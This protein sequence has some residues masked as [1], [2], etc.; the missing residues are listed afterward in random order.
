[1][2]Q[3]NQTQRKNTLI[4]RVVARFHKTGRTRTAPPSA[5]HPKK[6]RPLRDSALV[7]G[8]L[9]A[10]GS[11]MLGSVTTFGIHYDNASAAQSRAL[12][13]S[14]A[15]L[16]QAIFGSDFVTDNVTIRMH[17]D[18]PYFSGRFDDDKPGERTL[19][20]VNRLDPNNVHMIAPEL[21]ASDY[22]RTTNMFDHTHLY[23]HE[24]AHV[25]QNR[26]ND[27]AASCDTYSYTLTAQSRF[28]DF[29]AEQQADM[30][31]D[32][33]VAYLIPNALQQ[34]AIVPAYVNLRFAG[35]TY[36]QADYDAR[37]NLVRVI[38]EQFPHARA[39]RLQIARNNDATLEC[40][41][42][43]VADDIRERPHMLTMP[44]ST[45]VSKNFNICAQRH[46]LTLDGQT[47]TATVEV[48]PVQTAGARRP[49]AS[50]GIG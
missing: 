46:L 47:Q 45:F 19:G 24:M 8:S 44:R 16:A 7:I 5:S 35:G 42:N 31:A 37:T 20:Y 2:Q 34:R 36:T 25:W 50:G 13:T 11:I 26:Q 18:R 9:L 4:D 14:E 21:H 10:G 17:A 3:N 29:C 23:V 33:A 48:S 41:F 22:G 12:T 15:T 6:S 1:M 27:R 49:A 32:Y 40:T 43:A 28:E 30:I 38:E 39:A